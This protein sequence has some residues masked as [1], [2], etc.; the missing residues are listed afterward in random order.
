MYLKEAN[1][2]ENC[3]EISF[4]LGDS[5]AKE[6]LKKTARAANNLNSVLSWQR[7]ATYLILREIC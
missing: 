3:N 2:A 7:L 6:L 4:C 1:I 5:K